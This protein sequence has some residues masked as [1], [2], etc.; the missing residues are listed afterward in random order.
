MTIVFHQTSR[1]ALPAILQDGAL[2]P[3]A[4]RADDDSIRAFCEDDISSN[5]YKMW[6]M[7]DA[8][9]RDIIEYFLEVRPKG[10][11]DPV[12][13]KAIS[14]PCLEVIF[15]N[16]LG[17]LLTKKKHMG[18]PA[19]IYDGEELLRNGGMLV[20]DPLD[21]LL[22][23]LIEETPPEFWDSPRMVENFMDAALEVMEKM[24]V[25]GEPA[26]KKFP[27]FEYGWILWP[28]PLPVDAA[29]AVEVDGKTMSPTE[30]TEKF[31]GVEA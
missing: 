21:S 30:V 29:L 7:P 14:T 23:D 25:A 6:G 18:G 8:A 22:R 5:R 13:L 3:L 1:E 16:G 19:F 4:L 17:I 31:S 11:N 2:I 15:G 26:V 28:G 24:N 27:E 9:L 10:A 20:V 12:D